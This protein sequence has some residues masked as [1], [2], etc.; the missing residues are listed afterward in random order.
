MLVGCNKKENS[1]NPKSLVTDQNQSLVFKAVLFPTSKRSM[2]L[3]VHTKYHLETTHK[4]SGTRM[5][6]EC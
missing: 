3:N 6:A 1:A 4:L 5:E 2:E